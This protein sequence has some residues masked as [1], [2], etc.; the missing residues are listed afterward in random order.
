[1]GKIAIFIMILSCASFGWTQEDTVR[2][3]TALIKAVINGQ[4]DIVE[5]L[6]YYTDF[7]INAPLNHC[8]LP[9]YEHVISRYHGYNEV[10]W[11]DFPEGT[12]FLHLIARSFYSISTNKLVF[13]YRSFKEHGASERVSDSTGQFARQIINE[14]LRK[15]NLLYSYFF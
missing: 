13:M 3:P 4:H 2:C 6:L 8:D 14:H 12:T 15:H 9:R 5:H 11:L 10:E 7:D 1:M